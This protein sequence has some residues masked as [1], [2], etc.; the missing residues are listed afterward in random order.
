MNKKIVCFGEMLWDVLPDEKYPGGAPMNV[1]IHLQY[2][3]LAPAMVS[4]VG[5]DEEGEKLLDY[6][7]EKDVNC[8]WVQLDEMHQ[9]GVVKANMLNRTEVSYEIVPSVAWDYIHMQDGLEQMVA[10]SD[11]FL[12]GSLVA[13]GATSRSTLLSLLQVA[14]LKVL[15]V[16]MRPPFDAREVVEPLLLEAD[17]I[18]MNHHELEVITGWHQVAHRD[19]QA[20][21]FLRKHYGAQLVIVTRGENGAAVLD[22]KGYH[23]QA[24]FQVEVQDTI[25]SG[26]SFL[27]VFMA[28]YLAGK[29]HAEALEQACAVGALVASKKGATPHVSAE[30]IADL[31]NKQ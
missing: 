8:Q 27:A 5:R 24:G 18:K 1:A 30:A 15:D 7:R 4:R 10:Q 16:N 17:I 3:G 13:R 9:T 21:D 23:E 26:D 25:G 19:Q 11:V 28:N 14:N 6:L 22:A 29:S 12:F 31:I 20:M 2:Q